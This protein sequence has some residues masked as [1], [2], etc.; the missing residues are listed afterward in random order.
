MSG[1]VVRC[2]R[3]SDISSSSLLSLEM[4]AVAELQVSWARMSIALSESFES[5]IAPAVGVQVSVKCRNPLDGGQNVK[6]YRVKGGQLLFVPSQLSCVGIARGGAAL[7]VRVR[8]H[9]TRGAD[10]ENQ[11]PRAAY[12]DTPTVVPL[13]S[14]TAGSQNVLFNATRHFRLLHV[15]I[16]M[17]MAKPSFESQQNGSDELYLPIEVGG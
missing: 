10:W 11:E 8:G 1:A 7:V 17:I 5:L 9:H 12:I 4:T 15:R 6:L 3:R 16:V 2:C 14:D 13:E